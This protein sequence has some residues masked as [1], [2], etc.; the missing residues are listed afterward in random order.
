MDKGEENGISLIYQ[1]FWGMILPPYGWLVV[2]T[3]VACI[4]VSGTCTCTP[5]T[6]GTC[7]T[8]HVDVVQKWHNQ[9]M[10]TK[11]NM[12]ILKAPW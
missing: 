1:I 10:E 5:S 4:I 3:I 11:A 12:L 9:H 8:M 2:V 7:T 6:S